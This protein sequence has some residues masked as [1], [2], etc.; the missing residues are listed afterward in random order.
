MGI[1]EMFYNDGSDLS[2]LYIMGEDPAT[3][4]PDSAR[5]INSL[6]VLDFLVVQDI[7][8][9]ETAKYAN[10]VLPASSWAEK[11]GTF[12]NASGLSQKVFKLVDPTGQSMPD[13]MILKNL[14]LT[15]EKELGVRSLADVQ[16]E[17]KSIES[18]GAGV[19]ER[20][21][22]PVEF[23]DSEEPDKSYPFKLVIRDVLQ[24]SG[25]MSTSS[26]SLDLVISEALLEMSEEDA[27]AKGITDN[28]HVRLS[29]KQG[30]VFLKAKV[31]E[32]VPSGTVFVP[33]HF[34]YAK[35]NALTHM[36]S[37]GG[38]PIIAVNIERA[39]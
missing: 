35:I 24:H 29:S 26:K 10:V 3:S 17:I 9:T 25:S 8:L 22:V 12:T 13:W 30:S 21:F 23:K 28:S 16:S 11:D 33:T 37:N 18:E 20:K 38:A 4:F 7:F 39:K 2:A 15:M 32:E 31:S 36:S 27:K 1:M 6:K 19:V 34:P 5:V 14:A